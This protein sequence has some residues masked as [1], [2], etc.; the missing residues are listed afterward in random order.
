[1]YVY[2]IKR[3]FYIIPNLSVNM[4]D[5]KQL[6]IQCILKPACGLYALKMQIK[7]NNF[8]S[9]IQGKVIPMIS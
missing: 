8:H 2:K 5:T 7:H 3:L 9:K 4:L 6:L 1:M